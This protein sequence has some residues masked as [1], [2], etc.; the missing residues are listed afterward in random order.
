MSDKKAN[1][2]VIG[3]FHFE[4]GSVVSLREVEGDPWVKLNR[5][6]KTKD[7]VTPVKAGA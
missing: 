2:K 1:Y 3:K 6:E 5:L 4:K 7:K